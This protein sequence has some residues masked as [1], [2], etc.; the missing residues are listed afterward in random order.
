MAA[1]LDRGPAAFLGFGG[2]AELLLEPARDRGMKSERIHN[3]IVY[4]GSARAAGKNGGCYRTT[5]TSGCS[6]FWLLRS[7][8]SSSTRMFFF[9]TPDSLATDGRLSRLSQ[10]SQ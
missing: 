7:H 5:R 9:L 6:N 4:T 1:G 10:L 8:F 3:A 2:R